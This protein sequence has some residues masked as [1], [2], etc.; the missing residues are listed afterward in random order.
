[1]IFVSL[2]MLLWI[3]V[4]LCGDEL[5]LWCRKGFGMCEL[6]N[7]ELADKVSMSLPLTGHR[8]KHRP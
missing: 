3:A 8:S 1:M 5:V 7:V 2:K 6:E 4:R